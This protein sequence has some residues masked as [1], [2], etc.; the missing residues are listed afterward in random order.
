MTNLHDICTDDQRTAER[1]E[2]RRLAT[3]LA[4]DVVA[5]HAALKDAGITDPLLTTLVTQFNER[6]LGP[7]GSDV[8]VDL[9]YLLGG[10][11]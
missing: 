6:W 8:D 10:D 5:Y 4:G 7:V 9:A 1:R 2:A 11:D 3:S